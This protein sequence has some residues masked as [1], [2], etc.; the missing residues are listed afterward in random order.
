MLAANLRRAERKFDVLEQLGADDPAGLLVGVRRTRSTT[1]TSPPSSCTSW[2]TGPSGAACA[3]PTR[4]WRGAGSSTPTRTPGG[5]SGAPTIPL[6]ACASTAS[7]CCSRGD[8]PAGIRV[9]PGAKVFHVQLADAPRL[10]MDVVEWS[11]HHRLFP[12]LGLVRPGRLRRPR[13]D[14]PATTARCRSRSSTTS[15][16][17]PTP[18]TPP[19][20]A[21]ARCSRCRRRWARRH[22]RPVASASGRPACRRRPGSA[23]TCSPSSRSTTSPARSWPVP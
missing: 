12:G 17:R 7:T 9:V 20:T 4:R 19:S 18:G 2:P 14:A 6:S 21:C 3:S 16:G 11:R 5:S 10:N 8:D 13:A 23:A 15:T 22:R 1:T